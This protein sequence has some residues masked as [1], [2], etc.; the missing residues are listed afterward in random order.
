MSEQPPPRQP[1]LPPNSPAHALLFATTISLWGRLIVPLDIVY[2]YIRF[3]NVNSDTGAIRAAQIWHPNKTSSALT[4]LYKRLQDIAERATF[5][6]TIRGPASAY[7]P[8]NFLQ[9]VTYL[10]RKLEPY[11]WMDGSDGW[12][13]A[14]VLGLPRPNQ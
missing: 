1:E 6:Y 14:L 9:A 8:Y 5:P 3:N 10:F 12:F 13:I 7:H 11:K 2:H 4:C